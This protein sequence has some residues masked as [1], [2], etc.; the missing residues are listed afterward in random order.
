MILYPSS[1][2]AISTKHHY[3]DTPFH[4][5]ANNGCLIKMFDLFQTDNFIFIRF[6]IS[7]LVNIATEI[8]DVESSLLKCHETGKKVLASFLSK[9]WW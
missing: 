1:R 6:P 4:T 2:S 9:I 8:P 7:M 5:Q 3:T